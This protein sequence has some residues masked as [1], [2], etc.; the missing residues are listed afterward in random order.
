MSDEVHIEPKKGE[1]AHFRVGDK[2]VVV[3]LLDNRLRRVAFAIGVMLI[4]AGVVGGIALVWPL[5]EVVLRTL[6][7]FLVGFVFAYIFDPIVTFVQKRLRLS[8]VGG[9]LVLHLIFVGVIILFFA[10]L[11]PVLINQIKSAYT[12][13]STFLSEQIEN[14]S[15]MIGVPPGHSLQEVDAPERGRLEILWQQITMWLS[16]QDLVVEDIFTQA[17]SG[18]GV[19]SAATSGMR[20]VSDALTLFFAL[21]FNVFGAVMFLTFAVLVN[22]YLLMDFS[23]LRGVMGVMIPTR[24]ER[25][26]F[27]TLHKVDDAV[28]GFV[29]GMLIVACLVGIMTFLGL[30]FLGL[31]EYALLIG[32]IAGVGNLVPYLGPIMGATPALFYVAFSDVYTSP[33]ERV[34]YGL[35]VIL[36]FSVIQAIE[37]FILQPKVVG[38]SA[39]L[40]PIA[41]LFAL[42]FGANF[43]IIGMILAV[44][45]ACIARVLIKEFYWD[46]R[47]THWKRRTGAKNLEE[48]EKDKAI[49]QK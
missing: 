37:G 23:K 2:P 42:A 14:L 36:V 5:I 40:H 38:K 39:Q 20:V 46:R 29:R 44:P 47:E 4:A 49:V 9:V 16:E 45:L 41:V 7:P 28:G 19:R 3:E 18:M 12:G 1:E 21:V 25:R 8:R 26:T 27:S 31:R 11:L 32:V 22:I 34:L 30:W 15:S 17:T 6:L 33:Q 35:G 10:I 13:I 43:G 24:Y 48:W